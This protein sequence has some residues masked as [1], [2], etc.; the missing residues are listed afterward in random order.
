MRLFCNKNTS[1][2]DSILEGEWTEGAKDYQATTEIFADFIAN[3]VLKN[4][5]SLRRVTN[6]DANILVKLYQWIKDAISRLGNSEEELKMKRE[7]R[8]IEGLLAKALDEGRGG[9]S[10]ESVDEQM[11]VAERVKGQE[12]T[13]ER[14]S[15]GKVE[16]ARY[17]IDEKFADRIDKWDEKTVGFSFVVGKTSVALKNIGVAERQIRWDATKVKKVLSEHS[18]MSKEVIKQ[19][20][21]VIENPIV[22]MD[23]KQIKDRLVVLG[24]VYDKHGDIVTVILELQPT[25]RTIKGDSAYLDIIKIASAQGRS[26]T[27]GLINGSNIRY[28]DKNKNRVNEW[29]KVNR[30]Q[31]PLGQAC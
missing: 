10:L 31:L 21:Q 17:S 15:T 1:Y 20:P 22:I 7:M 28:I 30:L 25:R 6:R 4:E 23:S 3:E 19:V 13:A 2:Y 16:D 5:D 18:M 14:F 29:L 11:K 8:K 27:Q 26:N 12:K 9:I 24:D